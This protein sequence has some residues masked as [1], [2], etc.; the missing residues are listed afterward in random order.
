MIFCTFLH[1]ITLFHNISLLLFGQHIHAIPT[2]PLRFHHLLLHVF[3]VQGLVQACF[4]GQQFRFFGTLSFLPLPFEAGLVGEQVPQLANHQIQEPEC[5]KCA[6]YYGQNVQR[7]VQ[8]V[9]DLNALAVPDKV[10][11]VLSQEQAYATESH[12]HQT[13]QE[14]KQKQGELADVVRTHT[15]VDPRAVVIISMDA[16][17]TY[18]AMKHFIRDP[19]FALST[20]IAIHLHEGLGFFL[21]GFPQE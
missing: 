19:A 12:F 1:N 18:V 2:T 11:V 16:S 15:I 20:E 6:E 17:P 7:K 4:R 5:Q 8:L 3:L 9:R 21:R 13:Q 14:H 10:L